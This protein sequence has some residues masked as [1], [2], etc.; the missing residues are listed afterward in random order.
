[1]INVF[2][3]GE[4]DKLWTRSG[5]YDTGQKGSE[6]VIDTLE[7]SLLYVSRLSR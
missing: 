4:D 5:D 7:V 3:E 1:M 6:S 2:G